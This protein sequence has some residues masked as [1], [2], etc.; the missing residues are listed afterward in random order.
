MPDPVRYS[1]DLERP[2]PDEAEVQ[3]GMIAQFEKIQGITLKDYGRAV[4]GVH[5][6]A[7]GLL[8]GRLTVLPGLPP[9]LAQGLCAA[10]G[11]YDAV[12]RFSTNPGDIL[13]DSVSTPRGLALKILGVAGARLEDATDATT[14][15]FVMANAP[16]FTAPDGKAFLKSLKLLAATTDTPQVF[17]KAFSG[18]LRGVEAALEAVGTKSPTVIS[19]GGHP[20]THILG[21]TFYS[22]VPLRWG[23]YVA[24]IAVAP[25]APDLTALTGASLDVN[26]RPDGLREAVSAFFE[27]R[28]GIWDL[29]VQLL[30][31]PATM[32]VE[33]ASVPW[34]ET[35]SPY[36]AVAR[37]EVPPQASWD[38][39]KVRSLDEGLAFNPWH[40]LAAHRPLGSI[41]RAR[42]AVYPRSAGFRAAQNGCPIHEPRRLP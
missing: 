39:E 40:G 35:E 14:Q 21:E 10:P 18:L 9:A 33:D 15:D 42:R 3:A 29:R 5:A 25:V 16:A 22:Q 41:M 34:P 26:G 2:T 38:A 11:S 23:D 12:L 19:L 20:E 1:P 36:V 13:D 32:P 27:T 4:R 8:T 7:H 28:G 6:K 31:D 30:T 37:I 17:K 24:K